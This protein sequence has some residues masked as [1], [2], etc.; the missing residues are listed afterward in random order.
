MIAKGKGKGNVV[1]VEKEDFEAPVQ[2][3][4]L[5]EAGSQGEP[6]TPAKS[7]EVHVRRQFP[8]RPSFAMTIRKSQGQTLQAGGL[9]LPSPVKAHGDLYVALTRFRQMR[10]LRVLALSHIS[11]NDPAGMYTPNIVNKE[12]L[13]IEQF[14]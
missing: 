2:S 9:Y 7:K 12:L 8:L 4:Q 6:V 10:N 3:V 5:P 13:S 14:C 11:P 1:T